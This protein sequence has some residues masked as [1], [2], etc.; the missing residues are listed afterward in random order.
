MAD[1][2]KTKAGVAVKRNVIESLKDLGGDFSGQSTDLLKKTS[3]DFFRELMGMQKAS[4]KRSGEMRPGESM[5]MAAVLNGKEEENKKLRA[6]ISLERT[7]SSDEKRLSQQKMQELRVQLQAITVE[8]GKLAASTGNLATQTEIAMVEVPNNPGIYH[9]IFFE[10][11]LTFLQSFRAKI[12]SA[13]TWLEG[14]NKRAEKKNY[15]SMYKKKGSSF[16][17]SPDHYLSRAAG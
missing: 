14:S 15:W 2:K 4:V 10:K 8:I 12:D 16:L 7:L 13:T 5:D 17:L 3:E 11:V 9:V 6:Q 1:T